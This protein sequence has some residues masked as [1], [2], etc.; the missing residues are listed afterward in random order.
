[1][2]RTTW[3]SAVN[4]VALG[5]MILFNYWANALPLNNQTTGEISDRL[6]ILFTPADYTFSIW[7][8][9]YL[10]LIIWVVM[11]FLSPQGA[12][13]TNEIGIWFVISCA[14]NMSWLFFFHYE[15]FF[16]SL[17]VMFMLLYS[18]FIIYR[19]LLSEDF[20]L[21]WRIPFSI[22]LAWIS[23]ATIINIAIVFSAH[24]LHLLLTPEAWTVLFIW[25]SMIWALWF[26]Y[27][28]TDLLYPAVFIFS[29]IGIANNR[30]EYPEIAFSAWAMA[31]VLVIVLLY[32]LT[33][34]VSDLS[35][36]KK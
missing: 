5:L 34:M 7:G 12:K 25:L 29:L 11:L 23:V 14:L 33:P 17:I 35:K 32:H 6:N 28:R 16:L 19:R 8:L 27:Q 15:Y 36:L 22:Y 2:N 18:L 21:L 31:G 10:I 20:W 3:L 24:H 13:V 9:I 4:G 26:M 30:P 1:M